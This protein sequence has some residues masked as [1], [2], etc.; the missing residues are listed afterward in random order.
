MCHLQAAMICAS[1]RRSIF[2]ANKRWGSL[3]SSTNNSCSFCSALAP[4]ADYSWILC[5]PGRIRESDDYTT[6]IFRSS[7]ASLPA[8]TFNLF[9]QSSL[10]ARV[11]LSPSTN[12]PES[13][14]QV[15]S[16]MR[17]CETS[18]SSCH[19]GAIKRPPPEQLPARLV[20][21]AVPSLPES[22]CL[23]VST[24]SPTFEFAPYVTLS[25]CWGDPRK[26]FQ[27]KKET[28]LERLMDPSRGIACDELPA[29]FANA[30]E[31][32][33]RLGVRYIWID[34]LCIIQDTGEFAIEGQK[35]HAIYRNAWC[36]IAAADAADSAKGLFRAR[37]MRE[38]G[39]IQGEGEAMLGKEAW[40]VLRKDM[41]ERELLGR[42]LYTRGWVFQ[43]RLLLTWV[44][45]SSNRSWLQ[46][47]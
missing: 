25:H 34:A 3:H 21:L 38:L 47:E 42:V 39:A 44:L 26:L 36:T 37:E 13:W 43:G 32:A 10:Q 1:C 2:S 20:D 7:D 29:N 19:Q 28:N 45:S 22:H 17:T 14:D 35:M 46:R 5:K 30:I 18:H 9:S 11:F 24:Q 41:W 12:S 8:V 16:W 40:L 4:G 27:A 6:L 31:V 23:L 33:R 15:Q